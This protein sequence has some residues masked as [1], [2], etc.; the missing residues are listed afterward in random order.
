MREN[1]ASNHSNETPFD[2]MDRK[3]LSRLFGDFSDGWIPVAR[4]FQVTKRNRPKSIHDDEKK[5]EE[6][7]A[8]QI[9]FYHT[10]NPL[11]KFK[12]E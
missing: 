7:M 5:K 9:T 4:C 2:Q 10:T 3:V 6:K 1:A 11:K 12:N 8:K